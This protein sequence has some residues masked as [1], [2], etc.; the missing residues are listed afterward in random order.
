MYSQ[1]FV[2]YIQDLVMYTQSNRL[3]KKLHKTEVIASLQN[4]THSAIIA[5]ISRFIEYISRFIEYT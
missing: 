1:S 4:I 5:H 2:M 3:G